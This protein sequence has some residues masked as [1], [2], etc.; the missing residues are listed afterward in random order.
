MSEYEVW[1]KPTVFVDEYVLKGVFDNQDKAEEKLRIYAEVAD[2]LYNDYVVIEVPK[3]NKEPHAD[4][5]QSP[6][7]SGRV[8]YGE[9]EKSHS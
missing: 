7:T 5:R 2:I 4:N 6:P 9:L 3:S 1:R 8:V